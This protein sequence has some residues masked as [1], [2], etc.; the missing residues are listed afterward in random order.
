M[1]NEIQMINDKFQK[2]TKYESR[3]QTPLFF[4]S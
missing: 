1:T 2:N 3:I 4:M